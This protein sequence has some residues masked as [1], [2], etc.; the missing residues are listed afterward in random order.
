METAD[1]NACADL[2]RRADPDRFM[3]AMA[4]PVAAR[5]VLFPIYAF[6]V[7][8]ARAPWVTQES[9]IAEMRLQWWR[10]ALDEIR[11][12]GKVRRHE[13]VTPLAEVLD[14][15]GAELL[16]QLVAARRWDIYR[17]PFEDAAHF[18]DYLD[19]T[20]GHL[21]LAAGRALGTPPEDVLRD[22]GFAQ[23]LANWMR[24]IP[25]LEQSGRIPLPDGRPEAVG[26]LAAEGLRRLARAR[27][28]R[29]GVPRD[30]RPALLPAWQ[31]GMILRRTRKVPAR[32]AAGEVSPAPILSRAV[33]MARALS[34]RW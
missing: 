23:G 19:K 27:A 7:E 18:H 22:A 29:S 11:A 20:A 32:V 8:V 31:S 24:A 17:D 6:N 30:V 26:A 34:G 21:M 16:D 3:A 25:A 9:M 10:D 14:A 12:G 1:L 5:R 13:V 15:D 28:A 4:A 2:V 33:L